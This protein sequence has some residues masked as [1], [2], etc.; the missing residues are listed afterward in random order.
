MPTGRRVG[1][2]KE[3]KSQDGRKWE[4]WSRSLERMG[5]WP[6]LFMCWLISNRFNSYGRACRWWFPPSWA[7]FNQH[8]RISKRMNWL[9]FMAYPNAFQCKGILTMI[10]TNSWWRDTNTFSRR[11]LYLARQRCIL[12]SS[13]PRRR[14]LSNFG[15]LQTSTG[16]QC[17][18]TISLIAWA[19]NK[20]TKTKT[21]ACES[22]RLPGHTN[23]ASSIGWGTYRPRAA[24][25]IM[26]ELSDGSKESI[27][28]SFCLRRPI[29]T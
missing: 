27:L 24:A 26:E 5:Y 23:Y 18:T 13:E 29:M 14:K 21:F 3:W 4:C 19:K 6:K 11:N 28:K 20:T 9:K 8:Q 15:K 25:A 16:S 10:K 7:S 1:R 12:K 2:R 17:C 22:W